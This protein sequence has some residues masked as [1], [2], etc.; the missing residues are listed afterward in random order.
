MPNTKHI[1][2]RTLF[3]I[4]LTGLLSACVT[5][6]YGLIG[7]Q[8]SAP[9]THVD[10]TRIS[11]PTPRHE[12]RSSYGNPRHYDVRGKRYYVLGSSQNYSQRGIASWY[13]TKFHGHRTSSGEPYNMYAMTAAHKTLPL[14]T[15]VR[16]TNLD[17]NRSVVVKVNDRGP[18]IEGRIIDLSYVAARKLGM[19]GAGTASVEVTAIQPERQRPNTTRLKPV[20]PVAPR[21]IATKPVTSK[22]TRTVTTSN[23]Y[24]QVGL[25]GDRQNAEQLKQR[26]Q[27]L[28]IPTIKVTTDRSNAQPRYRVRVG[29]IRDDR[30]ANHVIEMLA[31]NGHKGFRIRVD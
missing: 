12:P 31:R 25:F 28:A 2:N 4:G 9:R 29:P 18:F 14:P 21:P 16:V 17:N 1:Y 6:R 15:Y 23:L 30:E 19:A 20:K 13:G 5:N 7:K 26:L 22:T 8:D 27:N 3:L 10:T 24:L 11:S